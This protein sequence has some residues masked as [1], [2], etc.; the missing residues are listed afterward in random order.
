[1]MS[2]VVLNYDHLLERNHIEIVE[3]CSKIKNNAEALINYL[4]TA[5]AHILS[6]CTNVSHSVIWAPN[7]ESSQTP[8]AF[9]TKKPRELYDSNNAPAI[10]TLFGFNSEVLRLFEILYRI[11]GYSINKLGTLI[12]LTD[13]KLFQSQG[14]LVFKPGME[15][16]FKT[17][18]WNKFERYRIA[19]TI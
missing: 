12:F 2:G 16:K 19:I 3:K 18:N 10:D 9:I 13:S 11:I 7:I 5:D 1:M 8:G 6:N 4:K 17:N 14:R 15:P